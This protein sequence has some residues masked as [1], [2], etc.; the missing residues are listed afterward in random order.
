[1][2]LPSQA[3]QQIGVNKRPA[4]DSCNDRDNNPSLESQARLQESMGKM[5]S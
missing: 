1:M 3:S 2:A 4:G 5:L